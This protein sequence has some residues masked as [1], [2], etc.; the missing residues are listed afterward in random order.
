MIIYIIVILIAILYFAREGFGKLIDLIIFRPKLSISVLLISFLV[1][2]YISASKLREIYFENHQN[3]FW[4]Q[5]LRKNSQPIN[6]TFDEYA[7]KNRIGYCWRD[8]KF[9]SEDELKQKALKNLIG[10]MMFLNKFYWDDKTVNMNDDVQNTEYYCKKNDGCRVI[11]VPIELYTQQLLGLINE[12]AEDSYWNKLI[13]SVD[14]QSVREYIFATDKNY[15]K[16]EFTSEKFILLNK[17]ESEYHKF[18]IAYYSPQTKILSK[19]QWSLIR[20]RYAEYT[21]FNISYKGKKNYPSFPVNIDLN[22]WGIGN[23]YLGVTNII[24]GSKSFL[25]QPIEKLYADEVYILNNCGD[26]LYLPYYKLKDKE[27]S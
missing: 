9:Y 26:V 25:F 15:N 27:N 23:Y 18:D 5:V 19:S 14:E 12:E 22:S 2:L 6:I 21:M 20:K 4:Y 24:Y 16:D 11:K 3:G 7:T 8:K 17:T 13:N 1:T 10:R